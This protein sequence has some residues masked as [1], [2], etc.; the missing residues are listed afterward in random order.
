VAFGLPVGPGLDDRG[1]NGSLISGDPSCEGRHQTVGGIFDPGFESVTGFGPDHVLEA[2]EQITSGNELRN[3]LLDHSH[4]HGVST[5]DLVARDGH[6]AGNR[7]SGWGSN[8]RLGRSS[9]SATAPRRPLGNDTGAT[10]I[11]DRTQ[12]SKQLGP[13][14]AA[15]GPL[16]AEP[17]QKGFQRTRSNQEYL[18]S[19]TSNDI[20][21]DLAAVPGA[22][23]DLF[24][25]HAY[26]GR[27][28]G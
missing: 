8:R 14:A 20:T 1:S 16:G 4:R 18:G 12:P 28:A 9:F 6:E 24:D 2:V 26:T 25:R 13:V 19:A 21:H 11:S 23:N 5:R 15:G 22:T 17:H 27:R 10:S 3:R 7:T